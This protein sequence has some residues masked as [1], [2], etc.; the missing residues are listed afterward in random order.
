MSN[1]AIESVKENIGQCYTLTPKRV[2]NYT[3]LF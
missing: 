2:N 3:F 1:T